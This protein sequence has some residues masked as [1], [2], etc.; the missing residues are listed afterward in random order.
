MQTGQT[1]RPAI[2]LDRLRREMT[3]LGAIG[4]VEHG[5]DAVEGLVF[6]STV[7]SPDPADTPEN[8]R[9]IEFVEA[10]R[11]RYGA[12]PDTYAAHGYDAVLILVEAIEQRGLRPGEMSFYLNT[13]NPFEGAAGVT[14]FDEHGDVRK[15]HRMFVVRD[16]RAMP[17]EQGQ[18]SGEQQSTGGDS[19]S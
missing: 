15:F 1:V 19:G 10:Y 2:N 4:R 6:P 13:M 12:T 17:L 11:A 3:E 8:Q 5:G 14:K 9:A 7:F 16:G 18:D